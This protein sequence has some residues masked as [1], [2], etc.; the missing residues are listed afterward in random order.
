MKNKLQLSIILLL[1]ITTSLCKAQN[2]TLWGLTSAGGGEGIGTIFQTNGAGSSF[3]HDYSFTY[4]PYGKKNI[5]FASNGLIYGMNVLGGAYNRGILFSYDT[6]TSKETLLHSFGGGADGFF[7][8]GSLLQVNDS[9]FYGLTTEGGDY[10]G[11]QLFSYN[12]LTG[13]YTVLHDFGS[14]TDGSGGIGSLIQASNG[15]LYGVTNGGGAKGHGTIF[16]Y[17]I[18]TNIETDLY[19]FS[20]NPDA[21]APVGPLLN[22]TS[23]L[24]YGLSQAGG[25][26]S[27]G[28]IFSYNISTGKETV[29][30]SFGSGTDGKNPF[31]ELIQAGDSLLYGTTQYGGTND[32]GT[33]FSYSISVGTETVLH[34]FKASTTDGYDANGTLL[35]AGNGLLYGVTE[36][37]GAN[38]A[39]IIYSYDISS[40]T[41][42][43]VFNFSK[44]S[45]GGGPAPWGGLIQSGNGLIYGNT[46]AGGAN[47][48]G[49]LFSYKITTGAETDVHDFSYI[50]DGYY[51]IGSLVK[52]NNRLLYGTTPYGG[53]HD[54]GTIFYYNFSTGADSILYNFGKGTDGRFPYF[55]S[56]LQ[57]NNGILYGMTL[58]GGAAGLGT[59]YSYNIT[60]GTESVLHSFGSGTDG[61]QPFGSLIQAKDGLIYGMTT[62]G[63][64]NSEG[65]IFSY[66]I[67][68][69]VETDLWNFGSGGDGYYPY[70]SLV[71]AG[72]GLLYGMTS[73]G[74]TDDEGIIFSYNTTSGTE[75][76]LHNFVGNSGDGNGPYGSLIQVIQGSDTLLYGMTYAG[77]DNEG[78][79]ISYNITTAKETDAHNF[80]S[81]TDG[82]D[83]YG[84]L[85]LG[86][87]GLL[88]GMTYGGGTFDYGTVFSYSPSTATETVI[89]DF[90]YDD[91]AQPYGNLIED[92]TVILNIFPLAATICNGGSIKL[93]PSGATNYTW[94]PAAGLSATTGDTVT[95]SPTATTTYTI[96]GTTGVNQGTTTIVVTV[97]PVPTINATPNPA[98]Y[99]AGNA[100]VLTA[101]GGIGYTWSPSTDLSATTGATVSANPT[102]TTTYTVTGANS[103]GCTAT[104]P[105]TVTVKPT[106]VLTITTPDTLCEGDTATLS[107]S[108][109]NSYTWSPATGLSATTGTSVNAN[110]T[111]TITYQ[112]T[113]TGANGCS[114]VDST[115]LDVKSCVTGIAQLAAK[116]NNLLI[117]PNP[118][119]GQFKV[120]LNDNQADYTV[121]VYNV[122]GEKIYQSVLSNSQDVIDLSIQPTGMYFIYLKS[123]EGVEVAKVL[124]TK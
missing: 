22:G 95:A 122:L 53:T 3:R 73:A 77:A 32:T 75:T 37:G 29:L 16:S 1:V 71:Q 28:A 98:S 7:P 17:N 49:N 61:N 4:P 12:I 26:N 115:I 88:Y 79:I 5:M 106:P 52:A 41:E 50:Y 121:E 11:G 80:G 90:E 78:T 34:S 74:G 84:S 67:N 36:G 99:C 116:N 123:N 13:S 96:T 91:G 82:N 51:P 76:D 94:S 40:G 107:V 118:S 27:D 63:G 8:V 39:G 45:T 86:S 57:A 68:T 23:G 103:V 112:I 83:P 70:G 15:L 9:L 54:S 108:G 109:G 102:V 65:T 114:S 44:N 59:I 69:G 62:A 110:P 25:S 85:V 60:T 97:N 2:P 31:G 35:L 58:K 87:D 56:L 64:T 93:I 105:V 21:S 38:N 117:Y 104:Q 89:H 18:S 46:G 111:S 33:I 30:H 92:D 100:S 101:T 120:N 55:C 42:K 81:G 6:S 72:N 10:G 14:G 124:V 20:G 66:N 119:S 43:D 48:A 47:S 113:G 19:D 24:F